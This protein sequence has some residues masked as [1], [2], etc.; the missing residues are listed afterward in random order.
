MRVIVGALLLLL[1][2]PAVQAKRKKDKAGRIIEG[3]YHD[4]KFG[5]NLET[6]DAWKI[7]IMKNEKQLRVV[8]VQKNY[9][10]PND[11]TDVPDFT[12]VPRLS[13]YVDTT[14]LSVYAFVDSLLSDSY[15]SKQ[16]KEMKKDLE[17]LSLD[18]LPEVDD[19][20]PRGVKR[21]QIAGE[22]TMIWKAQAKYVTEVPVSQSSNRGERVYGAYG[23]SIIGVKRGDTV[24]IFHMMCEWDYFDDIFAEIM[25]IVSSLSWADEEG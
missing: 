7:N 11:Y 9:L 22:K 6:N 25:G 4:K 1:L 23:A 12:K 16:K 24:Y 8:F 13:V 10:I 19:I 21:T 18:E 20:I 15:E 14:S 2:V 3:V 17:I 5:F